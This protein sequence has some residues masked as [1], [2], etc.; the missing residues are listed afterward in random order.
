MTL[1]TVHAVG[2][3]SE[4]Y[5]FGLN[6]EEIVYCGSITWKFQVCSNDLEASKTHYTDCLPE[7]VNNYIIQLHGKVIRES[8]KIN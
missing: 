2:C 6:A 8:V 4:V 7:I 1:V 3:T 5:S